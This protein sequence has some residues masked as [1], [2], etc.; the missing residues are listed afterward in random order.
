MPH[1][2]KALRIATAEDVQTAARYPGEYVLADA[3]S[4]RALGG[5]G[6]SFDWSLVTELARTRKLTLAG[7]LTPGNV[8]AAVRAV[9]PY[10]VDVASGVEPKGQPGIKDPELME[11]FVRAATSAG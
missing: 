1:A 3:R 8:A 10:C 9:R 11:A 6:K 7:G 4:E 5:T 2:Y